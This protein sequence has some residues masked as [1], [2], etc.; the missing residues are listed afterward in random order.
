MPFPSVLSAPQ[1]ATLRASSYWA[2]VLCVLNTNEEVF[3]ALSSQAISTEPFITFTYDTV[4]V[5]AFGDVWPGMV[6]YLSATSNIRDAFYRGRVRLAPTSNTF[7]IDENGSVI[8]DGTHVI[9]TRD[10]DLFSRIRRDTLVDGSITFHKL[11]DVLEGLPSTIVLYDSDDD[12]SVAYT[13]VQTPIHV[14]EDSSSTTTW[15]WSVSGAGSSSISNAAIQ[16][17]TITFEAGYHYLVRVVHTN[18]LSVVNY[19]IS[20]VYAI[21]RTFD[22]PVV[23]P[24]IAGSISGDIE[25][26]WTSSLTAYADVSTLLDRTHCAVFAIQRFGDNSSD[27]IVSNVLMNGRIRSD[28]IQ[29]EGSAEAGRIQQV[30]FAVEGITAY[31]RR[32]RIP[33]DIIRPD[34]TPTQWGEIE[35]PN[36]FRMAVYAMWVYSTLTN[37]S[38][39]SVET[40]AFEDWQIGG[41]P[42]GIDGGSALDVL[43]GILD[44][45]K[46]APNYAPTGEIHLA[47][48]V[49]Y[50]TDRSG[51]DTI[52]T[53]EQQDMREYTID[54]DSSRTTAQVIA[55]GGVYNSVTNTWILYTAQAPS[56]VYGDGGETRELTREILAA[57]ST[58]ADAQEEI[59]GRASNE[60]AYQNPKPLMRLSLFDSYAGVLIPTNFQRWVAT[61]AASTNTLGIAYGASD[62][63]Q[64][65]SVS[66]TINAN[67]TID[68]SGEWPA[69]TTF[70]DAQVLAALLPNNLSN[71]NPVLPVLPND[72][73][74]PTDPLEN[75]PT[76][77]P[78]LDELQ[79]IDPDSAAQAYTPFPPDIAAQV[80]Q[81]QGKAGCKVLQPLFSNSSNT[82]SSWTT[83]LNDPYLL[84]IEGYAQI[85]ALG[86][87][88][89]IDFDDEDGGFVQSPAFPYGVY[90][91]PWNH[92]DALVA[93]VYRRAIAIQRTGLT[94]TTFT[95]FALVYDLTKGTYESSGAFFNV[96]LGGTLIW[97]IL[98]TA[99]T[100]G[101]NLTQAW[102]GSLVAASIGMALSSC[103]LSTPTYDGLVTFKSI[104]AEGEGLNPYTGAGG[105]DRW[106]DAFYS[107]EKDDEGNEINV[108]ALGP[109]EGLFLDNSLFTPSSGIPPYNPSHRYEDVPFLGTGNVLL[110]RTVFSTYAQVQ[111]LYLTI[112][113]CKV[114]S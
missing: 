36:P 2:R 97:S 75:Y 41:E 113:V 37:I 18:N 30:T 100:N 60:Y 84:T 98:D 71:M 25:D 14:D 31:L 104:Y 79:P 16:N 58:I 28:S 52:T 27:P 20:H 86:W 51:V 95:H 56:I 99:L 5:G 107:W 63:W 42:R 67:G 65:Q 55:F 94:S 72:Y 108:T 93:G 12:G 9:V 69:E 68:A 110:A 26:G 1:K 105:V 112:E 106:A 34:A 96:D 7:Y 59:G 33:N 45:I 114:T 17:P 74:F 11:P 4:T 66:L 49:S 70:D 101:T 44:P 53:F 35:Q 13:T 10:T 61:I 47:R 46:A 92:T 39:F 89:L 85:S 76:D 29:T 54:R 81:R 109:S 91:P 24:V 87:T 82:T 32:L 64:L 6:V 111:K 78:G 77:D 43:M 102:D 57:D 23:Q 21:T 50:L 88:Q 62:Y 15:A 73:A 19:Q 8:A 103:Y 40:G 90:D 80:A 48:T 83:V 22:A 38:S 3:H